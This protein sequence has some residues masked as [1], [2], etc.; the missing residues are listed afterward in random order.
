[1]LRATRRQLILRAGLQNDPV[2]VP[3][4][5]EIYSVCE[6]EG[7]DALALSRGRRA[8][9]RS[10]RD[11]LVVANRKGS[12]ARTGELRGLALIPTKRLRDNA[13]VRGAA[14]VQDRL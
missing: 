14:T 5:D 7:F 12:G 2:R 13:I 4:V 11:N 10:I 6:A 3:E 1:L 9:E 8:N